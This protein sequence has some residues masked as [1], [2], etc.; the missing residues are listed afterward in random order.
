[1]TKA[2]QKNAKPTPYHGYLYRML[3][4]EGKDSPNGPYDYLVD[5]RMFG[6]FAVVAYPAKYGASGVMTFIVNHNGIV[7]QKDL[8]DGSAAEASAMRSFNPN[9]TWTMVH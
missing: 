8:G 9:T 7:Y 3:T 4:A 6:G 5:G 2:K 1:M